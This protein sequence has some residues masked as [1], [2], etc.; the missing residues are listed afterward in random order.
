MKRIFIALVGMLAVITA[1]ANTI[2]SLYNTGVNDSGVVLAN[3]TLGDPHYT[4]ITV[5]GG[6][7]EILVRASSGSYPIPPYIGDFSLSAWIGPNNDS[8]LNGPVGEYIYRT[9]FDLT[10]LDPSTAIITGQWATDNPGIDI[11]LN[12]NQLGIQNTI[13]FVNWSSFTINSGFENGMNTLDF[14]VRNEGGPTALRVQMT[15]TAL[16]APDSAS[17]MALLSG[18]LF[19]LGALSA[20]LG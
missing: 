18:A 17:T 20:K 16:P 7:S 3:G 9:T 11:V 1:S 6:S 15:G 4:L 5:P 8:S 14:V 19:L 13:Q 12:G 2:T 10:G